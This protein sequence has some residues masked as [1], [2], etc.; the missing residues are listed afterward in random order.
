MSSNW[1][2]VIQG[3]TTAS[4]QCPRTYKNKTGFVDIPQVRINQVNPLLNKQHNSNFLSTENGGHSK[5]NNDSF[6]NR[7]LKS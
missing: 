5:P 1:G 6:I 2:L 3:G 7:D 4:Y